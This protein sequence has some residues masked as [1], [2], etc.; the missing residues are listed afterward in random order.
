MS[1]KR[2]KRIIKDSTRKKMSESISKVR[3]TEEG[4]K[5][6]KL[7]LTKRPLIICPHC[8]CSSYNKGSMTIQHFANCKQNPS[9]DYQANK[10]RKEIISQKLKEAKKH[11]KTITCPHCNYSNKNMGNM[12][13]NHFD[14]CKVVN[15][16]KR[17]KSETSKAKLRET[18][19]LRKEKALLTQ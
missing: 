8:Q 19:R 17:E 2:C 5:N 7:A 15:P 3:S 10:V 16:I 6:Y 12:K 9:F 13:R 14:N 18:W 1:E 4:N 11:L